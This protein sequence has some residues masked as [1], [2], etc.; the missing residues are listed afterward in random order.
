MVAGLLSV[1]AALAQVE[2]AWNVSA[3]LASSYLWRGQYLGGL[4]FQP[5][6][7]IGFE[8]EHTSL[9]VGAWGNVGMSDW[10]FKKN[11]A[12]PAENSYFVPEAEA[13][14]ERTG[15]TLIDRELLWTKH[16]YV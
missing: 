7:S 4:S 11:S 16:M 15:V 9:S 2:F 6:V 8:G 5:E 13:L 3:D 12:N 1:T 14:A 10:K